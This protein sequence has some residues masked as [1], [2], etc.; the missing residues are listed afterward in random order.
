[1]WKEWKS[2]GGHTYI[3]NLTFVFGDGK[4]SPVSGSYSDEPDKESERLDN[5]GCMVFKTG[6]DKWDESYV[7][8][9]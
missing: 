1:L 4:R 5:L 2:S 7:S 8:N 9:I 6:I 3:G